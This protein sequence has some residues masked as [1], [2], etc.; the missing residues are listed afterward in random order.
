MTGADG[1]RKGRSQLIVDNLTLAGTRHFAI[2]HG[3]EGGGGDGGGDDRTGQ[4]LDTADSP[5]GQTRRA[6]QEGTRTS[7]RVDRTF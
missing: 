5:P 6:R 4:K 7:D 3:A 2:L 1:S